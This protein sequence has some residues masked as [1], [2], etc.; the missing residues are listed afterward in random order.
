MQSNMFNFNEKRF[1]ELSSEIVDFL[2]IHSE[3]SILFTEEV[4]TK[5]WNLKNE[6]ESLF[7]VL[8]DKNR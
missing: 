4:N 5:Y 2:K 8:V 7:P 6:L 3:H 1:Q